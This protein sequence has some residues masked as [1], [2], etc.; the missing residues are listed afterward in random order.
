MAVENNARLLEIFF[1]GQQV[2][3]LIDG[4][5]ADLIFVDYQPYTPLTAGNLPWHIVFGFEASMVTT[6]MVDGRIL[7]RDRKLTTLDDGAI[8]AEA[9]ALA[10]GV[11]ERY[12]AYAALGT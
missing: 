12:S 9:L 1:P 5:P 8:A 3:R 2:G 6:T 11:W 10:P 7:M 4:A